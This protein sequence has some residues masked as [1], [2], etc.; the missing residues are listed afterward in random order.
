MWVAKLAPEAIVALVAA[1][2]GICAFLIDR[3]ARPALGALRRAREPRRL[4]RALGELRCGVQLQTFTDTLGRAPIRSFD[5]SH[6]YAFDAVFVEAETDEYG[7]VGRFAVTVRTAGFKPK[8]SMGGGCDIV[9]GETTYENLELDGVANGL[10]VTQSGAGRHSSYAESYYFGNPGNYQCWVVATNAAGAVGTGDLRPLLDAL[11]ATDVALFGAFEVS[12][13]FGGEMPDYWYT[14]P[15]I[16]KFRKSTPINTFGESGPH[17]APDPEPGPFIDEVRVF[18]TAPAGRKRRRWGVW[19]A[20]TAAAVAALAIGVIWIAATTSDDQQGRAS[21]VDPFE[22]GMKKGYGPARPPFRCAKPSACDGPNYV[23]FNSYFNAPN[24]EDERSF[25]DAKQLQDPN[26][27]RWNDVLRIRESSTLLLRVYIDNNTFPTV[28]G[29]ATTDALD[30]RIRAALPAGPVYDA[31]PT[32]YIRAD[33]AKPR[34]IWDTVRLYSSRPMRMT[35]VAGSA[36]ITRR[37]GGAGEFVTE[38]APAGIATSSGMRLGRFK[39]DFANSALITFRLRVS[40]LSEPVRD[41]LATWQTWATPAV[42]VPA[43]QAGPHSE[44][45]ID[46][47]V[48]ARFSCSST[49]CQGAPYVTLNAYRDHPLLGDEADFVRGELVNT[50]GDLG[51]HRYRSVLRVRPGDRF[52]VRVSIDNGGDPD[53]IGAPAARR[54]VAR[55]I[56]ARVMLPRGPANS[57]SVVTFIDSPTA[58]PDHIADSLPIRSNRPVRIRY[59]PR[60]ALVASSSHMRRVGPRLFAMS[61][62]AA[63]ARNWGVRV[64]DIPPSFSRVTYIGFTLVARPG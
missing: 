24:Y 37:K 52:Y 41:P 9:L 38:P 35:Y 62:H 53:A 63:T 46:S 51:E 26:G 3:V 49:S 14:R 22:G 7:N 18:A 2:L 1:G 25:F 40:L 28:P 29:L 27:A 50:W 30:T 45:R 48:G 60:S 42:S 23:T 39:A 21:T 8:L 20:A 12:A 56:R 31:T 17:G 64:P 4:A 43:K 19:A 32:A 44:P 5:T 34:T 33:N 59:V 47:N 16:E 11:D 58:N 57:Q 55:A 10:A 61:D 54:L 6:L 13:P 36:R 15:A